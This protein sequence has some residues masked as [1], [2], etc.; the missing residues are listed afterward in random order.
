M[1]AKLIK[2][3]L[4]VASL[5]VFAAAAATLLSDISSV[6]PSQVFE[7]VATM[8]LGQLFGAAA[9]TAASYLLLTGYD[10]LA[11][12]YA[13]R[14]LRFPDVVFASFTA[15]AFS[16]NVGFQIFSGGSLRYRIYSRLGLKA[17]EI[18]E[19]VGFCTMT[20]VLGI[21]TVGGALA[22]FDTDTVASLVSLPPGLIVTT[23]FAF[24]SID[25]AYLAATAMRLG[26]MTICG[27]QLRMPSF[28]LA[29]TQIG[30]ASVDAA[31][32]AT[33][34]YALLPADLHLTYLSYL[35]IYLI[36]STVAVLSFVPGGIG[37]FEAA[38]TLL[39]LPL[40]KTAALGVFIVYRLVYFILPLA[41]ATAGFAL[42]EIR[43]SFHSMVADSKNL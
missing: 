28:G 14:D 31:L 9:L 26:P 13:K 3:F 2:R 12:L 25:A 8:P 22:L 7:F 37:V 1:K 42:Y 4:P 18:G 32:A 34:L 20:Y 33:V 21:V 30:L 43:R 27:Y 24:L 19:V 17:S 35:S 16:N 38:V 36:A 39:T 29:A 40:P 5:V 41:V 15:F 23:G 6:R 10:F 11:L